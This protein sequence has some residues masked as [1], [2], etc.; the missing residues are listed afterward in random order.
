ML[1]FAAIIVLSANFTYYPGFNDRT[2]TIEA[3]T[4]KGPIYELI[5][6]CP[7]GTAIISYSKAEALY[8][9]PDGVCMRSL[10]RVVTRACG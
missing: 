6:R 8:C 7:G 5:V 2:A 9:A 3:Y 4:D 10:K 1:K